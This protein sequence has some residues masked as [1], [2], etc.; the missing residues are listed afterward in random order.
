MKSRGGLGAD[1]I[2]K[3]ENV[4]PDCTDIFNALGDEFLF[5]TI[6]RASFDFLGRKTGGGGGGPMIL[7]SY[8]P[9]FPLSLV[10]VPEVF[11]KVNSV[12]FSSPFYSGEWFCRK[13]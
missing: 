4:T 12:Q 1:C 7:V 8:W 2:L 13:P 3:P 6:L 9:I 11:A 10:I 5:S